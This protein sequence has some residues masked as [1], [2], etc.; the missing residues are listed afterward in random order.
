MQ[1]QLSDVLTVRPIAKEVYD[2]FRSIHEPR[3]FPNRFDIN[4]EPTLSQEERSA[5]QQLASNM[6]TPFDLR[7]GFFHDEQLVGWSF[8]MQI[9]AD[10]FRM[11]TTGVLPE[12]QRQGIYSKF[13]P[14]LAE[15]IKERGFQ[16]ILSRHYA[17]DNQVIIPK[18]RFGFLISGFELT[19]QFG[20]LL[21]LSYVFNS[22]RRKIFHVRS[23]LAQPDLEVASLIR[24]YD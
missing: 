15:H 2:Q 16:T 20:L 12:Y 5:L 10:T 1:A 4:V 3:I 24:K 6:G 22:T 13:L 17:T 18:L 19:E 8:G 9:S 7:V 23:G 11:V 14:V 21:R